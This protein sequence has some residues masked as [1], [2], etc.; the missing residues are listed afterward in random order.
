[1]RFR[2]GILKAES[3]NQIIL[4]LNLH[5]TILYYVS[6]PMVN[7]IFHCHGFFIILYK[8][9]KLNPNF[10]LN[11]WKMCLAF[12]NKYP[13]YKR[14]NVVSLFNELSYI[15]QSYVITLFIIFIFYAFHILPYMCIIC[16]QYSIDLTNW[17][18]CV[19]IAHCSTTLVKGG[20]LKVI[21]A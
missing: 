2:S 20:H 6:Q 13:E 16:H 21:S 3:Y 7:H 17:S 14:V 15:K 11:Y 5:S 19:T 12:V 9:T 18:G 8:F 4:W 1:M 10:V